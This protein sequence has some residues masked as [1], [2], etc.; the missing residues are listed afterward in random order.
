MACFDHLLQMWDSNS[1]CDHSSYNYS[2]FYFESLLQEAAIY[3]SV[4]CGNASHT[5][6]ASKLF[7]DSFLT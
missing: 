4:Y 5:F 7:T 1:S 2:A 6:L 3:F